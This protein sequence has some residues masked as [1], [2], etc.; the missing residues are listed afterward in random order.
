ML[1]IGLVGMQLAAIAICGEYIG[2]IYAEAKSRPLYIVRQ[3]IG[4]EEL[5]EKPADETTTTSI[6]ST[7]QPTGIRLFR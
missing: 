1:L 2:R 5:E 3:A 4:F 6:K 7:D